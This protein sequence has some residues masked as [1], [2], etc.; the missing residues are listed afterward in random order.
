MSRPRQTLETRRRRAE[1]A[2]RRRESIQLAGDKAGAAVPA[3]LSR[4]AWIGGVRDWALSPN[5]ATVCLSV[6]VSMTAATLVLIAVAWAES[7]NHGDGR[8]AA[9]TQHEIARRVRCSPRTVRR[10]WRVLE[11]GGWAVEIMRGHG[12]C[13]RAG[14]GN[15]ASVWHLVS[16]RIDQSETAV[17]GDN[18]HLPPKAGVCLL[19]HVGINSPSAQGAPESN[20]VNEEHPQR[21]LRATPRPLPVQRLAAELALTLGGLGRAHIGAICDAITGAGIDPGV[22]SASAITAALNADMRQRGWYWPDRVEKPG[23]FLAARL[24]RLKWRE[25]VSPQSGGGAAAGL[26][27]RESSRRAAQLEEV[28]VRRARWEESLAA[29]YAKFESITT[30][31]QRMAMIGAVSSPDYRL[32]VIGAS[33]KARR[34]HPGL[35][36]AT[37]IAVWLESIKTGPEAEPDLPAWL[38]A[39]VA[40][41]QCVTCLEVPGTV[42]VGV[43]IPAPVCDSCYVQVSVEVAA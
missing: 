23:A 32:A 30:A 2:A 37:A 12:S 20:S 22:W 26:D 39:L 11:A 25:E 5:F 31:E 40:G 13:T 29:D 36:T 7:A 9:L 10:A 34:A 4:P 42:R 14:V 33:R 41:D 17:P 38:H 16:R 3:W 28:D 27:E 35:D 19:P 1:Y 24:G 15:R 43:P 6:R 18:V 8:N 21:A